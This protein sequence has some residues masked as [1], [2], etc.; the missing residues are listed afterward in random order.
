MSSTYAPTLTVASEIDGATKAV[1]CN[2]TGLTDEEKK[3]GFVCE[4]PTGRVPGHLDQ[5]S[6]AIS[7]VVEDKAGILLDWMPL[8]VLEA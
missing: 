6:Q 7:C 8:L 5:E 1:C 2:V 4:F 3:G